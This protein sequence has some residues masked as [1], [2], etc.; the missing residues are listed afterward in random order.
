M[1]RE[2]ILASLRY[3][4]VTVAAVLG[5]GAF[6][7]KITSATNCLNENKGNYG[8]LHRVFAKFLQIHSEKRIK[9]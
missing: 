6:S 4:L 9:I 7:F 1:G 2:S 3:E 5:Q 8:C